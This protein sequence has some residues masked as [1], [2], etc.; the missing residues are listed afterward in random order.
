MRARASTRQPSGLSLPGTYYRFIPVSFV[1]T[2]PI[3][4]V[5]LNNSPIYQGTTLQISITTVGNVTAASTLVMTCSLS[6][7]ISM[8]VIADINQLILLSVPYNTGNNCEIFLTDQE[9]YQ[10]NIVYFVVEPN[11]S[12]YR[13]PLK[14]LVKPKN[15]KLPRN[16]LSN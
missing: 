1:V 14:G 11:P 13:F 3:D 8:P 5:L 16:K 7:P 2:M 6:P 4:V 15:I 12:Y 10:S 9:T